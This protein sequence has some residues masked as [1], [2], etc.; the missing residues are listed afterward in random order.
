MRDAPWL[1][2]DKMDEV[3]FGS[4]AFNN[5]VLRLVELRF[6]GRAETEDQLFKRESEIEL[7]ST[8]PVFCDATWWM[9]EGVSDLYF[10]MIW[11]EEPFITIPRHG[12]QSRPTRSQLDQWPNDKLLPGAIN[13]S[14]FDGHTETV[15]LERLWYLQWHRK[16]LPH[17]RPARTLAN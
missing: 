12:S 1:R 4:Y 9:T 5:W 2:S 15:P 16:Y 6:L 14:F 7:P 11:G 8:T 17:K 10:D 13:V 3:F